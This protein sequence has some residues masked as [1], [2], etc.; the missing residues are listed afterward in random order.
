MR[1]SLASN[2]FEQAVCR[3]LCHNVSAGSPLDQPFRPRACYVHEWQSPIINAIGLFETPQRVIVL[4]ARQVGFTATMIAA[5]QIVVENGGNVLYVSPTYDTA[6]RV[7]KRSEL[8]N[9]AAFHCVAHAQLELRGLRGFDLVVFDEANF[10]PKEHQQAITDVEKFCLNDKACVVV[11]SSL[12][13]DPKHDEPFVDMYIDAKSKKTHWTI[14][15]IGDVAHI[16][17]CVSSGMSALAIRR[18]VLCDYSTP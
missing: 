10:M 12:S 3:Q 13:N 4:K 17:K 14:E 5:S 18:Q 8:H 6:Q 15:M 2:T 11:G 16:K 1:D 9:N 7:A